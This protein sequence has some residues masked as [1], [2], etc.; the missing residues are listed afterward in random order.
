MPLI[1][2]T[3]SIKDTGFNVANS[4]RFDDGSSDYLYRSLGSQ[5]SLRIGTFSYWVKRSSSGNALI[6]SNEVENDNN[7]GYIQFESNNAWRMVDNDNSGTH[8]QLRTNR[9]FRD[10]GGAWYHIVVRI[11]TTQSTSTDRVRLY[12]NGVQETSF[13]QTDY[14]AQNDDLKIFEGGQTNKNLLGS[15]YPASNYFDGYMA[16]FVY[17]DGQSLDP[18]SFGEFDSDT[19][20][21]KP[22]DVSGLTFG[23]N[24][25]YLDFEDSSALG[26]DVSGNNN[27]FT[28]NN[29]TSIDQSTDTCTNNAMNINPLYLSASS[30]TLENGN[31]EINGNSSNAWRSLYGTFGLTSGKWYWEIK[32]DSKE[33]S[34]PNN[35]A[36]GI[37]SE[38]QVDQ[39]SSNG[40][41]FGTAQG[42]AYHGK[43]GKKLNNDTVTANGSSY[44]DSF[45]VGDIVG[46][47]LDLD[48]HKL[49]FS[50]NGVVQASGDPTSGSTGTNSAFSITSGHTYFPAIANY[51]SAEQYSFNFGSPPFSISS[52]NS[53]GNGYGNFEYPTQGYYACNTKNLSE[54]G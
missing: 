4:L 42:Y 22:I 37:V 8:I 17:C 35:F 23:N 2:G 44:G 21:W 3:N 6:L 26:N 34:D 27:D 40:K 53:D 10:F 24:G 39:T 48:N 36:I 12:V 28:V 19:N 51:Y 47:F 38:D 46:V 41:F 54:F 50:K 9:L 49:Y 5:S 11:D 45:T 16:E 32:I 33:S 14:P 7:R 15:G 30:Y 29:L 31:L 20:I 25:F 18:T 13:D 52:G 1:L 43:D